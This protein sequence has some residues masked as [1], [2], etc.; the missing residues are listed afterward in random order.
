MSQGLRKVLE[1]L[2]GDDL[3]GNAVNEA[4]TAILGMVPDERG[5]KD[6]EELNLEIGFQHMGFNRC[7]AIILK[8]FEVG[9]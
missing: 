5:I 8:N 6:G 4:Y 3:N 1:N 7:R 2:W 9:I